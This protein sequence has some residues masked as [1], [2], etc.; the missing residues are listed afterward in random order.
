MIIDGV[1][2]TGDFV[3]GFW[4]S[5]VGCACVVGE[6][7]DD[8]MVVF[9][10]CCVDDFVKCW[11]KC[12]GVVHLNV[13]FCLWFVLFFVNCIDACL[14]VFWGDCFCVRVMVEV[15]GWRG[16]VTGMLNWALLV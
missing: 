13:E 12:K 1:E 11:L 7:V 15:D 6:N 8:D 14:N 9:V 2:E 10:V 5:V 4:W 16:V 3:E